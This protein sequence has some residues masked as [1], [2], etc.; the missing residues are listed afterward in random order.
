MFAN[1]LDVAAI[2]TFAVSARAWRSTSGTV[3]SPTN[4]GTRSPAA[5]KRSS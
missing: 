4:V 5:P 1:S 3:A 2:T